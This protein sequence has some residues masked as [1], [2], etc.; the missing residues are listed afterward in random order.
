M[1]ETH[2]YKVPSI[3]DYTVLKNFEDVFK[4]ILGFPPK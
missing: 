2:K 3:E 1:E 4:E